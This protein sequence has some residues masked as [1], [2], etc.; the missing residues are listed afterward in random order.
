MKISSIERVDGLNAPVAV[1]P[2][3]TTQTQ[4]PTGLLNEAASILAN[5]GFSVVKEVQD[6]IDGLGKTH[7]ILKHEGE[8]FSVRAK[9]YRFKNRASFGEEHVEQAA[10]RGDTLVSY[11]QDDK[12]FYVFD[13]DYVLENG[14]T[15]TQ[16]SKHSV[17]RTWIEVDGS[18]GVTLSGYVVKDKT[19]ATLAGGNATIG[20]F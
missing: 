19:P 20:S 11:I 6:S 9:E 8:L 17:S 15:Y 18:A 4:P 13:A 7:L 5:S 12:A 3:M 1:Q 10:A 16:P 2:D 14:S